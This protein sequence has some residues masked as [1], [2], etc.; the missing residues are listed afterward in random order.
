MK[1]GNYEENSFKP[2]K[3]QNVSSKNNLRK[4]IAIFRKLLKLWASCL[5]FTHGLM[6][7]LGKIWLP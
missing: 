3:R 4:A 5:G 6:G 7:K 2:K 1:F